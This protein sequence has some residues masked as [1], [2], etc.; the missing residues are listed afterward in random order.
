M[1]TNVQTSAIEAVVHGELEKID[2][3]TVGCDGLEFYGLP[4]EHIEVIRNLIEKEKKKPAKDR[5]VN[6]VMMEFNKGIATLKTRS[7]SS[8]ANREKKQKES[9]GLPVFKKAYWEHV[10]KVD[11]SKVFIL[12]SIGS[13]DPR[14]RFTD[15]VNQKDRDHGQLSDFVVVTQISENGNGN[16]LQAI[17]Y[18][19]W[20]EL[21]ESQIDFFVQELNRAEKNSGNLWTVDV[22]KKIITSKHPS[23]LTTSDLVDKIKFLIRP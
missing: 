15:L 18:I 7:R 11:Q 5:R 19:R 6:L 3:Q 22:S 9:L 14:T 21:K 12:S 16:I 17:L 2:L 8:T 1:A 23:K 10:K 13:K 4:P 20:V